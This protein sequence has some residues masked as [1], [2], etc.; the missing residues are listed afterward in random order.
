[1][2]GR[3]YPPS[4]YLTRRIAAEVADPKWCG[5]LRWP[6]LAAALGVREADRVFVAS[7]WACRAR[8]QVDVCG[9]YIVVPVREVDPWPAGPPDTA[10][11]PPF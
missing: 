2:T 1:V 9:E 6:E 10:G 4:P 8:G 11:E 7:V 3:R 5:G